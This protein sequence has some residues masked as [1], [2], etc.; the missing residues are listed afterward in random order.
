MTFKTAGV[1]LA[2]G[3]STRMGVDKA[4]APLA[5]QPLITHVAARFAPQVD[6]LFLNANGEPARFAALRLRDRRR[7]PAERRRRPAGRDRRSVAPCAIA[8]RGVARHRAV[9]RAVPAA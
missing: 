4:L 9:R 3:R 8:R 6:V 1:V 2:G 5:G 7:R